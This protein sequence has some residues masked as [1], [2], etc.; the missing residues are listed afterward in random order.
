MLLGYQNMGLNKF[1]VFNEKKHMTL[2]DADI[3]NSVF[4]KDFHL[5]RWMWIHRSFSTGSWWMVLE[6][7]N[8]IWKCTSFWL[9]CQRRI[10]LKCYAK[11]LPCQFWWPSCNK[12]CW[13]LFFLSKSLQ[14]Y[15]TTLG[16]SSFL[17]SFEKLLTKVF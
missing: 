9:F 17:L 4:P 14:D 1:W 10:P 13:I 12:L 15:G 8:F 11:N 6:D 3:N 16:P 7:H 5:V 2:F